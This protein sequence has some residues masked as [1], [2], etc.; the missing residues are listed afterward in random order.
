MARL[1]GIGWNQNKG[2]NDWSGRKGGY[3]LICISDGVLY[4]TYL[5][6]LSTYEVRQTDR[7]TETRNL[8]S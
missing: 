7:Q 2:G 6:L 8:K 1:D 4:Q 3:V 5:L